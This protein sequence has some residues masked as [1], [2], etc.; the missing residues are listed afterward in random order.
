MKYVFIKKRQS[1]IISKLIKVSIP[2][3]LE[4]GFLFFIFQKENFKVI[5]LKIP[6]NK[7]ILKNHTE[8]KI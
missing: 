5:S 8:K 1:G 6:D 2:V 4:K 3:Q 7:I